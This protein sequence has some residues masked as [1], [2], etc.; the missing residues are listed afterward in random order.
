MRLTLKDFQADTVQELSDKLRRAAREVADTGDLQAVCLSSTTG[1]G[2]TAMVTAALEGLLEGDAEN[3]PLTD[4]VFLWITDQPQLNEQT[5]RK[6][7]RDSSLFDESNLVTVGAA[8]DQETFA[9]RTVNFLNIQKLGKERDLITK[10]D[11]RR[12]TI[13]ETISNSIEVMP[14]RFFVIIDEAH[15]GMNQG[16]QAQMEAATI[17]QKFIVGSPGEIPKVPLLLGI[18]ATLD[19]FT[20]MVTGQGRTIRN[21]DVPVD[22]VR[23][24]GLLK[25]A[26]TFYHPTS[27]QPSD[28]TMLRQAVR[29]WRLFRD[30]WKAYCESQG[31]PTVRP[32][33]VVQVQDAAASR[34]SRTDLDEVLHAIEDEVGQLPLDS[35]THA[36]QEGTYVSMGGRDIRYLAPADIESD[37]GVQ[38]V[39][40]KTSLNTGWDCPRAEVMMS[41]RTAVDATAIAQLVGR[42]VRN[43]LARLI[44]S[45]ELLNNV[46]LYLPH[47]DAENLARVVDRLRSPDPEFF[48]PVDLREGDK[49]V[50][51]TRVASLDAIFN[52]IEKLPTYLMPGR[53][54]TSQIRRLMKLA[55]A[56][57]SDGIVPEAE[58]SALRLAVG[59]LVAE[60]RRAKSSEV[61]KKL[62][63]ERKEVVIRAVDWQVGLA[64]IAEDS[65]ITLRISNENLDDLFAEAG[66]RIGD[67]GL[68][69]E[70]WKH[71]R[72]QKIDNTQAKLELIALSVDP[73]VRRN[74]ETTAQR[75]VQEW[76]RTQAPTI[77]GLAD[78]RRQVYDEIKSLA[79]D[80]EPHHIKM[81]LTL[82]VCSSQTMWKNHIFADT[83][84]NFPAT[85]NKWEEAVVN[86]ELKKDGTVLW[87]RNPPRKP[88]SIT[89]PYEVNGK[90]APFYPDF[91][92]FR[93][94]AG[95]WVVDLLD[96]HLI[97]LAD[98]PAKAVGLAKYAAKHYSAFGRI[99]LII[100]RGDGEIRRIDL[101]EEQNR[102]MVLAVKDKA[103]LSHLFDRIV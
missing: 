18:S 7:V 21:V 90:P 81:P 80:P 3:Q 8:F 60:H 73:A 32:I 26:V 12:Y 22:Q 2:K 13:W 44:P 100:V 79:R 57:A 91:L 88:W 98:A 82:T 6:M 43:P 62:V 63:E 20:R 97:D 102:D 50:N 42:M 76:L 30:E 103:H 65:K 37:A 52:T 101:G 72:G 47:Y 40:F 28:I 68:H 36:F 93:R 51:V 71:R 23:A 69:R 92:F 34:P 70:W 74:I 85:L 86:E 56:L 39:F 94:L 54:K 9:P 45:N 31:E 27:K 61:F 17:V 55:R 95:K 58:D 99:E 78:R 11:A 48:P 29:S 1:S 25:E 89:V 33:L 16:P 75:T 35:Y 83:Q 87:L 49:Q 66:R 5:R 77:E 59:V 64:T 41:F 10:G 53:R 19:R 4:A 46:S 24:S 15:R 14:E 67:E 96:P 84:G 38:I